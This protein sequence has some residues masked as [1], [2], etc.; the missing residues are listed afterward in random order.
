MLQDAYLVDC[1]GLSGWDLR[2]F[3]WEKI[4]RP[5]FPVDDIKE[6]EASIP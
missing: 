5:I 4:P 1:P 3:E 6:W 2:T